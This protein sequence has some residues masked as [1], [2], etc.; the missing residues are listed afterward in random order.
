LAGSVGVA[1]SSSAAE[2]ARPLDLI[3]LD[4][5]VLRNCSTGRF[6][7]KKAAPLAAIADDRG[8]LR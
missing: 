8:V 3:V 2:G 7:T 5:L 1:N 4:G 6:S